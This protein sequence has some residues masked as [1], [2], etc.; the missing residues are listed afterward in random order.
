MR[1]PD[2]QQPETNNL[3]V[4]PLWQDED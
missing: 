2:N 1:F 3:I 4:L